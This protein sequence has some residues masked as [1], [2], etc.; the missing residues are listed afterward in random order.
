MK[1]VAFVFSLVMFTSLVA[2]ASNDVIAKSG[3]PIKGRPSG[4]QPSFTLSKGYFS[5]FNILPAP[6]ITPAADT[7]RS[8]P[9]LAPQMPKSEP[10][11]KLWELPV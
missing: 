8:K 3:D 6:A 9:M 1:K 5:L 7:A 4:Q 10:H 2:A 11:K